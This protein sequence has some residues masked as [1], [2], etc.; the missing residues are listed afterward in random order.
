MLNHPAIYTPRVAVNNTAQECGQGGALPFNFLRGTQ[1]NAIH[2]QYRNNRATDDFTRNNGA[3]GVNPGWQF[4]CLIFNADSTTK[5]PTTLRNDLGV[6]VLENTD[7]GGS[8]NGLISWEWYNYVPANTP[9]WVMIASQPKW[10]EDLPNGFFDGTTYSFDGGWYQD[11]AGGFLTSP[12]FTGWTT[13]LDPIASLPIMESGLY[14]FGNIP[15]KLN[16]SSNYGPVFD[17]SG[18]GGP[19]ALNLATSS[20]PSNWGTANDFITSQDFD[21]VGGSNGLLPI[22][23]ATLD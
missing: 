3:P 1:I 6:Q 19:T 14:A 5:L 11:I 17:Y 8:G 9:I 13:E 12:E 18:F 4:R 21:F 22:I 20:A 16:I 7:N 15:Q 10:T 23:E 2:I